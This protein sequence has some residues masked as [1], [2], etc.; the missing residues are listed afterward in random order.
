MFFIQVFLAK[1]RSELKGNGKYKRRVYTSSTY[2]IQ[3]TASETAVSILDADSVAKSTAKF[4]KSTF[5]IYVEGVNC[6]PRI[7]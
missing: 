7:L 5:K 4:I 1:E 2:W 6:K 3:K